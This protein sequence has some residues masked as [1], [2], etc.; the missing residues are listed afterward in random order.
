MQNP[1]KI[2]YIKKIFATNPEIVNLGTVELRVAIFHRKCEDAA[3]F[4]IKQSFN[5]RKFKVV[6]FQKKGRVTKNERG[7][8]FVDGPR[9]MGWR[10]PAFPR[11]PAV[12]SARRGL[13][14]LFGMGRG[15]PPRCSRHVCLQGSR[16]DTVGRRTG[17]SKSRATRGAGR[18]PLS[19]AVRTDPHAGSAKPSGH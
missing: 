3:N 1:P 8:S 15:G 2:E 18:R 16:L 6:M 7:P 5:G 9:R 12:S 14:S 11:S 17:L 19:R 4:K 10:R 13:T